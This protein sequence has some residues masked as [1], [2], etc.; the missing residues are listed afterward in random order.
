MQLYWKNADTSQ[1]WENVANWFEDATAL[2]NHGA[3]PTVGDSCSL[4][5]GEPAVP[6][7]GAT[8]PLTVSLGTGMCNIPN[9]TL[10]ADATIASGVWFCAGTFLNLGNVNG[11]FFSVANWG[12][13]S[14]NI[15]GGAWVANS[16]PIVID[17]NTVRGSDTTNPGFPDSIEVP[18]V[19]PSP[20]EN[21]LTG[22]MYCYD[23]EGNP[24][25]DVNVEIALYAPPTGSS[26]QGFDTSV[27]TG[28]SDS[29]GYLEFTNLV[30]GA[31][32]MI[33][34]GVQPLWHPTSGQL[35]QGTM[36]QQYAGTAQQNWV[37]FVAEEP[38]TGTGNSFQLPEVWGQGNT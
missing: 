14:G 8:G 15:N 21:G 13:G 9:I 4:A 20:S 33:R 19:Y 3:L 7:I 6:T 24:A 26:G 29:E 16:Q 10:E 12:A 18:L 34:R 2:I 23:S 28:T 32:Y 5:T 11:G 25:S 36:Y 37:K 38:G 17:G 30:A 27:R 22:W 35:P 1:A 31:T